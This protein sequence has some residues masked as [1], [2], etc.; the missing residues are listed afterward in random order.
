MSLKKKY[1]S[2]KLF[3]PFRRTMNNFPIHS[4]NFD[5]I[6]TQEIELEQCKDE[7]IKLKKKLLDTRNEVHLL[8]IN[9]I[10]LENE[11]YKTINHLKTFLK[12]SDPATRN[13]YK[14]IEQSYNSNKD[15]EDYI[16]Q[17]EYTEDNTK[18]I[19]ET[20]DINFIIT[21]QTKLN[22]RKNKKKI[23]NFIKIDSL[24]QHIKNLNE[25]LI[26]KNSEID[27]LKKNEKVKGYKEM[28]KS[29]LKN[30][31][32]INEILQEENLEIK[33]KYETLFHLFKKE[34]K[35]N[36]ALKEKLR[37]FNQRFV[38]FKEL[39]INKVKKLDEELKI[40]KEKERNLAIKKIGEEDKE[41]IENHNKTNEYNNM[42]L[43]INKYEIDTKKNNDLIKKY[44]N[45][46]MCHRDEIKKLKKDKEILEIQNAQLMEKNEKMK[47]KINK[48]NKK[49]NELESKIKKGEKIFCTEFD[50]SDSKNNKRNQDDK[51]DKDNKEDKNDENENY[52]FE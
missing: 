32:Q 45:E 40:T 4:E 6:K 21:K 20:D 13:N 43:K 28:Q 16:G 19:N 22:R 2:I 24:R 5:K 51:D 30:C 34:Q 33:S 41:K 50:K 8:K 14:S 52:G 44:K 9:K 1:L 17:Q 37:Q 29:L 42:K 12:Q 35:D 47:D 25:E 48:M 26:R 3:S 11:H 7:I 18:E 31:N 38:L 36:I 39:S 46:N 23:Q 15:N 49:I 10:I 27:E